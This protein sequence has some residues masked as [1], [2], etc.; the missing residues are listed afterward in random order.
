MFG[1]TFVVGENPLAF[2]F[3]QNSIPPQNAVA[4]LVL[5]TFSA[6][7]QGEVGA[8][9]WVAFVSNARLDLLLFFFFFF[10]FLL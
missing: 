7:A 4:E 2:S 3:E 8:V 1:F 9:P 6:S 10:F 5:L